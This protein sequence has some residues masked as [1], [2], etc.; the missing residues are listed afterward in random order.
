MIDA[1][2]RFAADG[3]AIIPG[4][5]GTTQIAR[6]RAICDRILAQ[7][8]AEHPEAAGQRTTNMAYLTDPRYFAEYEEELVALLK[9]IAD[10]RVVDLLHAV[11]F[12]TPLFHNT[13]YF[14]ESDELAWPGMWHRD[15]Q[16]M[17][18][19]PDTERERMEGS[20]SV[21]FRI[22]FIEDAAL[23]YVPRSERRWDEPAELAIRLHEDD[24]VRRE[25]AMP[26]A[27]AV[28]LKA[29]DAALFHAWGIHRGRYAPLPVGRSL[30]IIYA[31]RRV[32]WA[33]PS[34]MDHIGPRVAWRLGPEAR[35]FFAL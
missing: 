28:P 1:A 9:L 15:T 34:A 11:G 13:Q 35:R 6:Y 23:D 12:E 21:H 4:F 27:V 22:A 26:G 8:R 17:A 3:Y 25:S 7:W 20:H 2:T 31:D 32:A 29:G 24:N 16:F 14:M 33:P 18:P 10:P 5:M 30:D 19:N